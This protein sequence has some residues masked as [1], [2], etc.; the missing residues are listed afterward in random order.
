MSATDAPRVLMLGAG[1]VGMTY[2]YHLEQ[3]GASVTYFVKPKYQESVLEETLLYPLNRGVVGRCQ[4]LPYRPT[5]AI[6]SLEDLDVVAYDQVW[7]SISST[8]LRSDMVEA[9][10]GEV[11]RGW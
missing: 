5:R 11:E 10:F 9:F 3:G 2:G 6:S 7:I 4:A 8:A 1:A